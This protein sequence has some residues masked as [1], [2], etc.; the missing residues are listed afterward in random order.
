M[1]AQCKALPETRGRDACAW[2]NL[3]I[4]GL[5]LRAMVACLV[6]SPPAALAQLVTPVGQVDAPVVASGPAASTGRATLAELIAFALAHNPELAA[7]ALDGEGAAART[8]GAAAARYPRL[9]VEGGYTNYGDDLRLVAA[10]Y[11]G[12]LGVFGAN[13]VTADLVLRVPVYT[14]GRLSAELQA[15]ELLEVSAGQR[16]ARSRGDLVYNVS[17]LYFTQLAQMRLIDALAASRDA[18]QSQLTRVQA[19]IDERKAAPVDALRT[20]VRLADAR[21]RLLRE[22][23]NLDVLRLSLLNLLGD[24]TGALQITLDDALVAPAMESRDPRTLTEL[25]LARRPDIAAARTELQAQSARIEAARAGNSPSV[26]LLAA[27]GSRAMLSPSQQPRDTQAQDTTYRVGVVFEIPIFDSGRTS[28]RVAEENAK[29][30]AQRERLD[31]LSMQVRLDI[32]TAHGSLSSALERITSASRA[33]ALAREN[34]R[35]EQEKYALGRGTAFDVLDAQ[36]AL[37]D[38]QA[39]QIR[40]LADANTAAAQLAWASG[41]NLP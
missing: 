36:S 7:A 5:W 34:L 33:I 28:A 19:L 27:G 32:E 11:N 16:L 39:A 9:A 13:V 38:T 17:S 1:N 18:L 8:R 30:A 25:A 2:R 35:I 26:N 12:E 14:G 37:T 31:K 4:T 40:A 23:N 6:L 3:L 10:R 22:Q 15:A 41:E 21:Q 20:E 29:L 24:R